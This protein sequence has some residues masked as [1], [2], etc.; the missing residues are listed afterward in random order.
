MLLFV[1]WV[2]CLD[3]GFGVGLGFV[4]GLGL[5]C[6]FVF[7]VLFDVFIFFV[8]LDV[9]LCLVGV[10]RCVDLWVDDWVCC[11]GFVLL[12]IC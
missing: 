4:V 9:A 10:L 3:V 1:F 11:Y 6:W 7:C 5:V 2:S 12:L 8:I